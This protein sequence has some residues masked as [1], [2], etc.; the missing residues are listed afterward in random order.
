MIRTARTAPTAKS[1]IVSTV[2]ALFYRANGF[3][4][5]AGSTDAYI[6]LFDSATVP[7]N[8]ATPMKSWVAQ[9]N[10]EFNEHVSDG[11]PC[12][13]GLTLVLSTTK[14]TLTIITGGDTGDIQC[15]YEESRTLA[16][17]PVT[18][19][20]STGGAN[21]LQIW[22]DAGTP[23][24]LV[25][26]SFQNGEAGACWLMA[27]ASGTPP[28]N[29]SVPDWQSPTSTA[30]NGTSPTYQFGKQGRDVFQK[31]SSQVY[32]NGCILVVSS[33]PNTLTIGTS[34]SNLIFAD[35]ITAP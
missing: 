3:Y 32:H 21:Y 11:L 26:C 34:G 12:F 18:A 5:T 30:S 10:F 19:A 9:A 31:D 35:Y 27:F 28:T 33:T 14:D 16:K 4:E 13:T 25:D 20:A 29:G 24:K 15:E 1:L 17:I 22:A 23:G 7:A 8:G 2:P 6:M